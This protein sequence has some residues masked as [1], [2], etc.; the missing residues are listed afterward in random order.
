MPPKHSTVRVFVDTNLVGDSGTQ[1]KSVM[2]L[3]NSGTTIRQLKEKVK[4]H[5]QAMY[6]T[7][8]ALAGA[9]V[10]RLHCL[11]DSNGDSAAAHNR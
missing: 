9:R 8:G 7:D 10:E 5:I 2:L 3:E 6:Q 11:F 1:T 4:E